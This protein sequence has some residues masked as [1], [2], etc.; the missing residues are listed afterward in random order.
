MLQE[1]QIKH[2]RELKELLDS[3]VLSEEEFAREKAKVLSGT[4]YSGTSYSSKKEEK[5]TDPVYSKQASSEKKKKKSKTVW[6]VLGCLAGFLVLISL[7]GDLFSGD[8]YDSYDR[9]EEIDTFIAT[10]GYNSEMDIQ[11]IGD[12]VYSNYT[13]E[14]DSSMELVL[15]FL[16][17]LQYGNSS[18]N[19]TAYQNARKGF[20]TAGRKNPTKTAFYQCMARNQI[21]Y[22]Y[23]IHGR[24][25][26]SYTW[27]ELDRL[28]TSNAY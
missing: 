28:Y 17:G 11:R 18:Y 14:T 10:L 25:V 26:F 20:I 7:L 15:G 13:G 6:I 12:T 23:Q 27:D 21:N 2:L 8:S 16:S 5:K 3:G 19:E 22:V 4:E 1:E 9:Y 24:E